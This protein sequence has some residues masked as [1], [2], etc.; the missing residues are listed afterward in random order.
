MIPDVHAALRALRRSPL[1]TAAAILTLALGIGATTT[2]YSVVDATMLRPLPWVDGNRLMDL[3]L[4][5]RDAGTRETRTTVW[6]YPKFET[7]RGEQRSFR[8]V[9]VYTTQHVL[10]G[11]DGG[12]ERVRVEIVSGRYFP[13]LH[14]PVALGRGLQDGDDV[15]GA[16][17]TAVLSHALWMRRYGGD[18]AIVGR[19]IA[20]GRE[21][22]KVVG[23]AAASFRALSGEVQLWTPMAMAPRLTY[24][25][26]LTERWNH[27]F[28]AIG[29]LRDGVT[30]EAAER[31]MEA[32]GTRIDAAH[33]FPERGMNATWGARA[34]P[35]REAREDP[36]TTRSLLVLLGAVLC[37]LL[38]AC[39]NVANLLLARAAARTREFAVRVAIGARRSHVVRQ[40]LGETV[41]LALLGG[42]LGV[43]LAVWSLEGIRTL[44]PM[45]QGRSRTQVSQYL[46]LSQ[47]Q[48]DARVL[49]FGFALAILTGIV[50]GLVPALR[51]SRP[52]LSR[53]LKDGAGASSEGGLT[54]RRGSA[55]ALLV[56][57]N[58]ALSMLLL[59]GAGLLTRSF[60]RARGFDAGF[61][62][63]NV[64]TFR[65][66][67]PDDSAYSGPKAPLF[68]ERLIERL[69]ALPGVQAVGTATCAPLS[70]G[71]DGTIVVSKDGIDLP[72]TGDHSEISVHAVNDGYLRALGARLIAG[73]FLSPRDGA[74]API[75]GVINETAAKRLFP[76]GHAVGHHIGIGF[77]NWASVE[78]V[79]VVSDVNYDGVGTAPAPAFYGSYLQSTRP[80]G[81]YFLRS[82]GD[83]AALLASARQTVR[84]V[85]PDVA[86][87]DGRT[88]EERVAESL[89]RL[90]FGTVLLGA[91]AMLGLVLSLIGIYAVLAYTVSQR[92]RELGIRLA[93]GAKRREVIGLVMRRAMRLASLGVG[94][95]LVTAWAGS[96]LL[97]GLVFG[98][99]TSDPLTFAGQAL[100]VMS[101]CTIA[102]YLP[103]RRA[104]R[105]DPV[106]A[107]RSE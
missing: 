13:M 48:L 61:E 27:T 59:V 81:L 57:A 76:D 40:V 68:R 65:V 32:L 7:M 100:L 11:G 49:G 82:D 88:L 6:S 30:P 80:S 75:V 16:P 42:G 98:I 93:L 85:S 63:R 50:C 8:D 28:D 53:A 9:A 14:A 74:G 37:V 38:I 77:R 2:I 36:A 23:V 41:L 90:R 83:P 45:D 29:R 19:D 60:A 35:L 20:L 56:T 31:E 39:V 34:T 24:P 21:R 96:R 106:L 70:Q 1:G 79:G 17:G 62:P 105:L 101:A 72:E 107:L 22:L 64:L 87:Y 73:R 47:V 5:V 94:I 102:S 43:V 103:A 12:T 51:A 69:A 91:F 58:V 26:L 89:G 10:L 33:P 95:G 15:V 86:L 84:S 25:E 97:R 92:T 4:T 78:I 44:L 55:R 54:F 52:E 3:S 99:S 67:P 18:S 66:Q 104:A 46:D 71:C